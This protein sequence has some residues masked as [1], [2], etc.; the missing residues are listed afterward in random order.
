MVIVMS[1]LG[2]AYKT[3]A[4]LPFE[5]VQGTIVV[6]KNGNV[7]EEVKGVLL[8]CSLA[9]IARGS[10]LKISGIEGVRGISSALSLWVFDEDHFKRVLG[11]DWGDSFGQKLRNKL[12]EGKIPFSDGEALVEKTYAEQHSL[13]IG[14]EETIS[15]R[16]LLVTGIIRTSG[17]EIVASDVYLGLKSAQAMAYESKNL[18]R[19]ETFNPTD[20]N[21]VF[22]DTPL[23][24][25]A[26]VAEQIKTAL[27][28]EA[29]GGETPLGQTIGTYNIYTSQSF[30]TQISSFFQ[31]S[32]RLTQTISLIIS[33]G[34]AL[35]VTLSVFHILGERNKEFGLM[36]SV[37]F[38]ERDIQRE[39]LTET[40]LQTLAGFVGGFAISVV[41][42]AVLARTSVSIS[43]P[44]ELSPYPHFLLSD[45]NMANVVQSHLLPIRPEPLYIGI[46]L[47]ISLIIGL[48]VSFMSVWHISRLKPMEI[49]RYE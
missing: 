8:S 47:I 34:A 28:N 25:T 16:R 7:P 17:N 11:A 15:G 33:A 26:S 9:P 24:S 13:S 38:R 46:T 22:I 31:I 35:L 30:E 32:D 37:G 41:A 19:V 48:I 1:S 4:R 14:S 20:V 42:I 29:A 49:L 3:A 2:S 5:D 12:I 10:V 21:V 36:K 18:Q 43:I 39:M 6:Q 44:W 45:P 23:D 40:F 27:N